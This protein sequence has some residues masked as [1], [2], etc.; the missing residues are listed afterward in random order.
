MRAE[1]A[2]TNHNT[3][4]HT[5]ALIR[6]RIVHV[7]AHIHTHNKNKQTNHAV[8]RLPNK[9]AVDRRID[10]ATRLADA[11]ARDLD[12][13]TQKVSE[14][15]ASEQQSRAD[16]SSLGKDLSEHQLRVTGRV[17]AVDAK[18]AGEGKLLRTFA[19]TLK[20]NDLDAK[21]VKVFGP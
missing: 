11:N 3:H 2:P 9:E 13:L 14:V 1:H 4:M 20:D 21:V 6:S 12:S 8:S 18:L 5:L 17:D 16:I 15:K 10:Q 19:K 7:R